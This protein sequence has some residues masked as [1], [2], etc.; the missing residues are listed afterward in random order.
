MSL[1]HNDPHSEFVRALSNGHP[2]GKAEDVVTGF[3]NSD[4]KARGRPVELAVD[5]SGALL[6]ADE[7]GNTVWR[8]G[9]S[10]ASLRR[11]NC[12][13][14]TTPFRRHR[15]AADLRRKYNLREEEF[16]AKRELLSRL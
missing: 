16:A 12:N 2:N 4:G 5:K 8:V 13:W 15:T 7:V 3:L 11:L 14:P 9:E 6:I 10:A 1:R